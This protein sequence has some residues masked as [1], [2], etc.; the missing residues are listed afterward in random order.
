MW[1]PFTEQRVVEILFILNHKTDASM[2]FT[3]SAKSDEGDYDSYIEEL[4]PNLPT[5]FEAKVMSA[6]YL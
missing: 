2:R 1:R 4:K 6:T 5:D 3:N